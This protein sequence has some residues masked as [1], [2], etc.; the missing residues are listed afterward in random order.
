M[1][2]YIILVSRLSIFPEFDEVSYDRL[3]CWTYTYEYMGLIVQVL[4]S[5]FRKYSYEAIMKS[6]CIDLLYTLY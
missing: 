3:I 5:I 1:C 2:I 6:Y 4:V